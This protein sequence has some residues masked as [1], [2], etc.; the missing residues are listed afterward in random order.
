MDKGLA[1]STNSKHRL[2]ALCAALALLAGSALGNPDEELLPGKFVRGDTNNDLRVNLSDAVFLLNYLF[3]GGEK[4][5]CHAVADINGDVDL[6]IS[7]AVFLLRFLFLGESHPP[8]PFP[9]CQ[10]DPGGSPCSKSVCQTI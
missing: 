8:A 7:D 5:P 2:W 9:E 10:D 4:P 1:M 3:G 6:D